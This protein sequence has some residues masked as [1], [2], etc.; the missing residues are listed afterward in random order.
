[1]N[2]NSKFDLSIL[3]T[4]CQWER[5]KITYL[6][7]IAQELGMDLDYGCAGVNPNSGYSYIWSENYSF[8][9]Y[10]PINCELI[11]QDIYVLW[12]NPED[13]EETEIALNNQT[14]EEL[15]NWASN[16]FIER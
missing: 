11:K 8:S 2:D 4:C 15:E 5:E 14:L 13:G 3:T 6:L 1:M 12:T 16:L 10:M 9:L 7:G